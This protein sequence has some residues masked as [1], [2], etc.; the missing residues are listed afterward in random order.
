MG[1]YSEKPIDL[2]SLASIGM[3]SGGMGANPRLNRRAS[4]MGPPAAPGR[5]QGLGISGSSSFG[6]KGGMG[7][8]GHPGKTSEERFAAAS[9]Q[10]A[11]AMGAFGPMGSFNAG[12]RSQPSRALVAAARLCHRVT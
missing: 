10:R 7:S 8:F 1:V 9:G 3:E 2:P 12:A 6:G 11:S 5:A 4:A